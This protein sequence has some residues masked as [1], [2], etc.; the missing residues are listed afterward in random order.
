M[1]GLSK[2]TT[3]AIAAAIILLVGFGT[4]TCFGSSRYE[5]GKIQGRIES[6]EQNRAAV[7]RA[8]D[9]TQ[10]ALEPAL[11][12]LMHA[13]DSIAGENDRLRH[14][15]ADAQAKAA[16]A[17]A[18]VRGI[19]DSLRRATDPRV[20]AVIDSLNVSNVELSNVVDS[21]A[22]ANARLTLRADSSLSVASEMQRLQHLTRADLDSANATIRDLRKLKHPPRCGFKCGFVSATLTIGV[23]LATIFIT[24]H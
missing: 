23:I 2:L 13:H 14:A 16:Q 7:T 11:A 15:A 1:F 5:Q 22:R 19:S 8:I 10:R 20:L 9:S 4:V 21:L 3:Q 12:A 18:L 24:S 6:R 17:R